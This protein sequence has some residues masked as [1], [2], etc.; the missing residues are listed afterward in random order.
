MTEYALLDLRSNHSQPA[1][2]DHANLY[3]VLFAA[4]LKSAELRLGNKF[5]VTLQLN[6][7]VS[8]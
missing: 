4:E 6:A 3:H 8:Q 5:I 2:H 7:Q 1:L